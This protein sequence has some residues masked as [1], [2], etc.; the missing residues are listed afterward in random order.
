MQNYLELYV[1]M[2]F[3]PQEGYRHTWGFSPHDGHV[4][5]WDVCL[6]GVLGLMG[7]RPT[8]VLHGMQA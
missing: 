2:G 3:G 8:W 7:Y 4:P 1:C 6:H 5:T